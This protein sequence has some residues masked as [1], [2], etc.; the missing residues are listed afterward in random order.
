MIHYFKFRQD[1]FDPQPASDV[2]IKR[3]PGR[4]W[5]EQC[6]PIRA[7]N[8]FGFDLLANFDITFTRTRGRWTVRP[9]VVIESDFDYSGAED[10]HG[11]P[12]TQ[13]FAWFW[14]KG[15]KLP[16][17][18]SD[19]VYKSISNQVK[20]SS[21]L[22]LRTDPNE[23]LLMTGIPNLNRPWRTMTALIDTDWYPASYPWHTVIELDPTQTRIRI[24][25]GEPLCRII[26]VRRDTYFAKPMTPTDFDE[27]FSRGQ[28]W[29]TTH[30][31][32]EH[33][34]PDVPPGT[35]DITHTYSRQQVRS[36]FMR[37]I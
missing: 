18:I 34:S 36:R 23:L 15:Q 25:K 37:L 28:Q 3:P 5:P 35:M 21:Y 24:R 12:L 19:N 13:Q 2:Y 9:D 26:P 29:L 4:G 7:A 17:V 1:L 8:S 16:H 20:I 10:S 14:Q 32:A 31:T 11:R 22:F 33:E 6:P 30:G 27:F